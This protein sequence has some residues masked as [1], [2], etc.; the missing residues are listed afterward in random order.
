MEYHFEY[1]NVWFVSVPYSPQ[2]LSVARHCVVPYAIYYGGLAALFGAVYVWYK[3][4]HI[5]VPTYICLV[6]A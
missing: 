1:S 5:L 2:T 3:I 4:S 6:P